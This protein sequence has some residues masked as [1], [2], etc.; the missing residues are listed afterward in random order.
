M[1]GRFGGIVMARMNQA[2]TYSVIDLLEIQPNDKV[3][4]VGFGSGV[5]I[6]RLSR[7]GSAGYIAGI[8]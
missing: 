7:L 1:L 4:K 2:F 3:L 8:G 5:G 6:H